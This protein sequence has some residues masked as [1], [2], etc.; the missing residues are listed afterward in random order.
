MMSRSSGLSSAVFSK[1]WRHSFIACSNSALTTWRMR[2]RC[3]TCLILRYPA[4]GRATIVNGYY[5]SVFLRVHCTFSIPSVMS[6]VRGN[7]RG[8]KQG[9]ATR[10]GWRWLCVT[11]IDNAVYVLPGEMN[12]N[13]CEY[14][15]VTCTSLVQAM[16]IYL[17]PCCLQHSERAAHV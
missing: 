15:A 10:L 16:P 5:Y 12:S 9:A 2:V 1:S 4:V 3:L 17:V 6:H 14:K 13:C 8:R 11:S 7:D